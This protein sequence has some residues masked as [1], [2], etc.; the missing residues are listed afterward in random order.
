MQRDGFR[1]GQRLDFGVGLGQKLLVTFLDVHQL[2]SLTVV[3]A[4]L[5]RHDDEARPARRRHS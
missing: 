1:R 3:D 5:R 4:D 2:P